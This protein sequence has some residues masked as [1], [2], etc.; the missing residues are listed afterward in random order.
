MAATVHHLMW[1]TGDISIVCRRAGLGKRQSG[2]IPLIRGLT[3]VRYICIVYCRALATRRRCIAW[4]SGTDKTKL[5]R[6]AAGY[7]GSWGGGCDGSSTRGATGGGAV[8]L[9]EPARSSRRL[10]APA[11]VAL[12][13]EP[14]RL[15]VVRPECTADEM[16]ALDQA[17]RTAGVAALLWHG[18]R[19]DDRTFRRLQLACETSGSIALLVRPETCRG[20]PSW[21][22]V[23]MFVRPLPA[24]HG[25]MTNDQGRMTND[26]IP[27][28]NDRVP[29]I[30]T[31]RWLRV[32]LL[33]CR[34][35]AGGGIV[36]LEIDDET[37][38]VREAHPVRP[39]AGLADSPAGL[40]KARA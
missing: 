1:R 5:A 10:Y 31:M 37:G 14:A 38:L 35:A 12:G 30:N 25:T 27:M 17:A 20:R 26:Q 39:A 28:T 2:K 4:P 33:R 6:G 7:W 16:W 36:E 18:E 13:I 8:V 24:G 3:A 23:R 40:R 32:E 22:E 15:V 9:V 19:L 21:A 34:A 29:T 11:A